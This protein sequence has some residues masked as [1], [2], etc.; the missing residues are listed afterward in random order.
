MPKQQ[1]GVMVYG[2]D[3][4]EI[5]PELSGISFAGVQF[6]YGIKQV[7]LD[8][9]KTWVAATKE[10]KLAAER[11]RTRGAPDV[12]ELDDSCRLTGPSSCAGQCQAAFCVRAYDP[13]GK[14]YYCFCTKFP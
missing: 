10:D 3:E 6:L 2:K 1:N 7:E 4:N 8:G 13:V 5:P 9:Q 14:V 11:R 12:S